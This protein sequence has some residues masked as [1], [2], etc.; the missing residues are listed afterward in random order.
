[1][2]KPSNQRNN[3]QPTNG[4]PGQGEEMVTPES[5]RGSFATVR[6]VGKQKWRE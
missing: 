3:A 5:K 2:K 6:R 1:M 4:D